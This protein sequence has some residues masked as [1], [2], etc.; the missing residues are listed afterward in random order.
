M[1]L[2]ALVVY[3]DIAARYHRSMLGPLWA[4]LKP[5][6]LMVVF[7]LLPRV[8]DVLREMDLLRYFQECLI[9]E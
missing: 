3:R 7:S 8:L 1:L 2:F 6:I 4:I 9:R 5:L